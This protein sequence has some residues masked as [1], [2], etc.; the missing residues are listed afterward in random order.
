MLAAGICVVLLLFGAWY[1]RLDRER[2]MDEDELRIL[3]RMSDRNR[4]EEEIF[5]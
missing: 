3:R 5:H 2:P 1:S 4:T